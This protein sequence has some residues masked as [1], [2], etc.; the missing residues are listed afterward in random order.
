[1]KRM[2]NVG[3]AYVKLLMYAVVV[4]LI[5]VA[6]ST[7]F[8]R[9]DLTENRVY[10]LSDES[11]R[12]VGS[13]SDPLTIKVFFSRN[14]PAPY[15]NLERYL[16]DLLDEYAVAG[17]RYFNYEFYDI[18]DDDREESTRNRETARNYGIHPVQIQNIEQDQ[19]KFQKAYMGMAL[20]QGQAVEK[21]PTIT[22]GDGLEYAITGLIRRL[23]NKISALLNLR[24]PVEVILFLSSSLEIVG[25][26]LNLP[27][28]NELPGRVESL[29]DTLN[30][31]H[32][33]KLSFRSLDPTRDPEAE[34]EAERYRLLR[35]HWDAFQDRTGRSLPAG[36]GYAGLVIRYG[37]QAEE[38]RLIQV[39]RIPVFG[40]RYQLMDPERI[41]QSVRGTVENLIHINEEIGVLVSHG[42]LDPGSGFTL[43][44]QEKEGEAAN[45]GK[46]LGESYS[47]RRVDLKK[48]P[49]PEALSTLVIAGPRESFS[50]FELYQID[51]FLMKGR[52][53]LLFL[54]PFDER[55]PGGDPR[56]MPPRQQGPVYVPVETGLERLLQ[57]Y[58]LVPDRG[59][60]LDEDCFKQRIPQPF[61]G[62]E[63]PIYFAPIIDKEWINREVGVLGNI[64]GLIMLKAAPLRVDESRTGEQSLTPTVLVS[65]SDRSWEMKG[66]IDLNP[67]FMQ[68]PG[69]EGKRE[70]R[71]LACTLEGRF[72]SFFADRPLPEKPDADTE[73][74]TDVG[75]VS[76]EAVGV[77][78]IE[79][80][81][82]T[83]K[84]GKPGKLFLAG[85]S[86]ILKDSII[87]PEGKGPNAQF[88]MNI[89]D[90]LNGR[91]ARALM[92]SKGQRFNPLEEIK[93]GT[94]TAVKTFLIAG[95][96]V[97]VVAAGVM[98]WLHRRARKR[99]IQDR[100]VHLEKGARA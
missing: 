23:N 37:G 68:P 46:I 5:N 57:H 29:V 93:P 61:G 96:P 99:R 36:K 39:V 77:P 84:T 62:G 4:V 67:M 94:R 54:D 15:N 80:G 25:P 18:A 53:L 58:G 13:L 8:F 66:R 88:V 19:V 31:E 98:V 44:G 11:R 52:N 85:T 3:G 22:S 75:E 81:E 24:E 2:R 49:I 20:I 69:P 27:G 6:G 70:S 95:L 72:S 97:L 76:G 59:Y 17:N 50:D 1:M 48:E 7:L 34:Q 16:R 86:E 14:L 87:D 21:I 40:T 43:P 63:R 41:E 9:A 12:A 100:F 65:S 32:Y 78:G 30:V 90:L 47:V 51:Q 71:V 73:N 79:T 42:S 26:Y 28:L 60:V 89:I 35:L 64:K 38:I 74:L 45:F 82:A 33:G 10:S 83:L 92:R 55:M 56:M 91:E